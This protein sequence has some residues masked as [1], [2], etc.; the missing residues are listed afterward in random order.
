MKM[1]IQT[2]R[3]TVENRFKEKLGTNQTTNETK[4]VRWSW[5]TLCLFFRDRRK[6][7]TGTGSY[8]LG[9]FVIGRGRVCLS[10]YKL[11][12][13]CIWSGFHKVLDGNLECRKS[14]SEEKEGRKSSKS[15][16]EGNFLIPLPLCEANIKGFFAL[17]RSMLSFKSV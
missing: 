16:G 12:W 13:L 15:V 4:C 8:L 11:A 17:C 7:E 2:I 5:F 3:S 10:F 14:S 1:F 6:K 9:W